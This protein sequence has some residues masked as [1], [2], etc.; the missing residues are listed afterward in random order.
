VEPKKAKNKPNL[1]IDFDNTIHIFTSW[2]NNNITDSPLPKA[3]ESL[4]KLS[5]FFTITIFSVRA[6]TTEGVGAIKSYM[7]K[8]DLPFTRVTDKKLPGLLIDDSAITFK[9]DWEQTVKDIA[10]FQNWQKKKK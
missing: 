4:D 5:V 3:K 2:D 9:G 6:Q 10:T 1:N 7:K 8:H